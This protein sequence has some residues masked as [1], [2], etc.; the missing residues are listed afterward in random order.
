[1]RVVVLGAWN[2]EIDEVDDEPIVAKLLEALKH[3]YPTLEVSTGDTSRG[4]GK[5]VKNYCVARQKEFKFVELPVKIYM[6]DSKTHD[7]MVYWKARNNALVEVGEEFHLFMADDKGW[8]N[9]YDMITKLNNANA[10]YSL[11]I[12]Y[13]NNEPKLECKDGET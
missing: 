13:R 11:Y 9:L 8:G 6:Q 7:R 12:P 1:M 2:R 10:H 3:R 4:V 5:I